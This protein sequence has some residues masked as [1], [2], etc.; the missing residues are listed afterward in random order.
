MNPQ[1][2][3]DYPWFARSWM[4]LEEMRHFLDAVERSAGPS[5]SRAFVHATTTLRMAI[6]MHESMEKRRC[7]KYPIRSNG[8]LGQKKF[9][10]PICSYHAVHPPSTT[11]VDPV[12]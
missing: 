11:R 4:F 12:M 5:R 7:P 8:R 1:A 6:A 2:R 3:E 9:P 10:R